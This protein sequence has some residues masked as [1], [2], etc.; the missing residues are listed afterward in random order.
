M[1]SRFREGNGKS[2]KIWQHHWLPIKH[3]PLVTSPIIE[4][5]ENATVDYLIDENTGKWDDEM[6]KGILIPVEVELAK[7]IPVPRS[8]TKDVLYWPFTTNGQYNCRFGYKFLKDLEMNSEVSTQPKLD[9]KFWRSI[10][11]LKVLKKFKNL[12]CQLVEVEAMAACRAV[13]LGNELG[14]DCAIVEGDSKFVVKA[15][16]CK[17]NGLTPFAHLINDVS[18]FSDLFSELSYSHIRRDGN[19]VAHSLAKLALTD[20]VVLWMEDVPYRTLPFIQA[21]LAAL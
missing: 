15:L 1:G 2:I 8:Q 21:D 13:E 6:L 11:S 19:K 16:R 14:I 18:L 17:D 9:K 5:M 12:A 3:P 10:W 4:S 20:R 7:K